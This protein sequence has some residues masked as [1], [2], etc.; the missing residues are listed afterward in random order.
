MFQTKKY[1]QGSQGVGGKNLP[2]QVVKM[3]QL[4][5]RAP[6]FPCHDT[7]GNRVLSLNEETCCDAFNVITYI[8]TSRSRSSCWWS[9]RLRISMRCVSV[10]ACVSPVE[11]RDDVFEDLVVD[12][13]KLLDDLPQ[14]LQTLDVVHDFWDTHRHTHGERRQRAFNI[15]HTHAPGRGNYTLGKTKAEPL[16]RAAPTLGAYKHTRVHSHT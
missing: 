1:I 3:C 14:H 15:L 11:V 4:D 2:L 12:R 8:C 5:V 13:R 7:S 10:C 16:P 9:P 6:L